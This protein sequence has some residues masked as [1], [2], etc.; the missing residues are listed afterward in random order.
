[1]A[2]KI[3]RLTLR[4]SIQLRLVAESWQFSLQVASPETFGYTLILPWGQACHN[5]MIA[6]T[7]KERV[8]CV[9]WFFVNVIAVWHAHK[10]TWR[11]TVY[12]GRSEAG[13][14]T[15]RIPV[16]RLPLVSATGERTYCRTC[17]TAPDVVVVVKY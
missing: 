13:H 6:G 17:T 9:P 10:R 14:Y 1:V 7:E 12:V 3:T 2:A 5:L 8:R 4:I 11:V 16:A 15:T